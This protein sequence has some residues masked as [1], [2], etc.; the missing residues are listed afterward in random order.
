MWLS[1]VVDGRLNGVIRVHGGMKFY[2]GAAKAARAYVER[3]RSRADDYYL[4][5]GTGVADAA[6]SNSRRRR[7]QGFD[8]RR[9]LRAVGRRDRRRH[10]RQE[11]TA[12]QGCARAAVRRGHRQRTRRPGR[13]QPRCTPRSRR[14]WMLPRTRRRTRSSPG[15]PRTPRLAS[16]RADGRCRCRSRRSRQPSSG[17]TR[18]APATRTGTF[19]CRSTHASSP[20]AAGV[21]STPSAS[22]TRSRPSTASA[23]QQSRPSPGSDRHSPRHGLTLD[24]ET[25][26]IHEL[27][28]YVG[29]FSAQDR[30]DPA[31]TSTATR[32]SGE[33]NIPARSQD[34]DCERRGIGGPGPRLVQTRSS[35]ATDEDWSSAGAAS[36]ASSA[37]A[38]RPD[39]SLLR[40]TQPGWID[41]DAAAGLIVSMLGCEGVSV[42]RGRHPREGRGAA[43]T[44]LSRC[45]ARRCG[46]SWPRTSP[47]APSIAAHRLLTATD[48]P[49]HVRSLVVAARARR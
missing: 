13:S 49:E 46:S 8:G 26:E 45:R 7:A 44:D 24:P 33:A 47:R 39:P 1:T 4:G 41:R 27:M 38:I 16:G 20:P 43:R 40:G 30:A 48:V 15:W 42:E 9:H 18:P 22:A 19:T 34:R 37:T 14:R 31:A 29:A 10:R 23:T 28:P 17:I 6:G 25:S 5:E 32:P 12:A 2:R 35:R 11:G 36:C 3:D 21:A